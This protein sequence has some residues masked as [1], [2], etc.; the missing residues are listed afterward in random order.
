MKSTTRVLVVALSLLAA[1]VMAS[2]S[3]TAVSADEEDGT[4]ICKKVAGINGCVAV[5]YGGCDVWISI[6]L[7]GCFAL[8]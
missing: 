1:I 8:T 6:G 7:G 2:P 3:A 4:K 5:M